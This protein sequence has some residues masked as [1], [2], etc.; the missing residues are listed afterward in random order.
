MFGSGTFRLKGSSLLSKAEENGIE[1]RHQLSIMS[2]ISHQT[3]YGLFEGEPIMKIDLRVLAKI[4]IRGAGYT[5][6]ELANVKFGDI[7]EYVD[8]NETGPPPI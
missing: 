6:Q 3:V 1:N 4:L 2:G 5:P 8:E 7:F